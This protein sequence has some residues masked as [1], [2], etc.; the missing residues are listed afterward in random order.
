M[1]LSQ[2]SFLLRNLI[3]ILNFVPLYKTI[4]FPATFKTSLKISDFHYLYLRVIFF[5]LF[6]LGSYF[7]SWI[8]GFIVFIKPEKISAIISLKNVLSPTLLSFK[9]SSYTYSRPLELF[10]RSLMLYSFFF[11]LFFHCFIFGI[12][13]YYVFEITG[14]F[15][16]NV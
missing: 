11:S 8:S 6:V 2:K 15:F 1:I 5:M 13:Y 4:F 7:A 9:N 14:L 10:H 12:L 16:C 3:I